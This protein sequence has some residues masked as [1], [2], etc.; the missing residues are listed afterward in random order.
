M[1]SCAHPRSG[2]SELGRNINKVWSLK[3]GQQSLWKKSEVLFDGENALLESFYSILYLTI[4][5]WTRARVSLN[6]WSR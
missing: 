4:E 3:E 6:C 5:I 1:V 2:T